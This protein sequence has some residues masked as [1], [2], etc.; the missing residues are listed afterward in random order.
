LSLAAFAG[1]ITEQNLTPVY[2]ANPPFNAANEITVDWLSPTI[3]IF[4]NDLTNINSAAAEAALFALPG[5]TVTGQLDNGP[6]QQVKLPTNPTVDVFFVDSITFCGDEGPAIVGCA[7]GIPGVVGAPPWSFAVNS[8]TA[9]GA[10]GVVLEAHEL[11]HDLGL[12]HCPTSCGGLPNLMDPFLGVSTV[13]T[14]AQATTILGNI[15]GLVQKDALGDNFIDL[16]AIAVVPEPDT[17]T[18][19]GLG[20]V[21][22]LILR[23]RHGRGM[24]TRPPA[25]A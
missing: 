4:R 22:L 11:G 16:Q 25:R 21:L 6:I 12:V 24:R 14:L 1:F 17:V 2:S 20:L 18:M 8:T 5:Q 19:L 7:S 13:V 23:R 9:A 3:T 10:S 15:S